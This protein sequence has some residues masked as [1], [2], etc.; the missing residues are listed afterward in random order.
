MSALRARL[1]GWARGRRDA[2]GPIQVSTPELLYYLWKRGGRAWLRGHVWIQATS[3]LDDPGRGLVIGDHTYVGP[4][5]VLGA[6]GGIV[7]GANVTLG[8]AVD[9]LAENHCFGD[10]DALIADQGVSRVG[11]TIEDDV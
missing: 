7:I 8:A 2:L 11:I 3:R 10:A 5:C 9:L 6:G 4:R 1:Y